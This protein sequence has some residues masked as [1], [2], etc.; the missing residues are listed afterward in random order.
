MH[1]YKCE[2]KWIVSTVYVIIYFA[3]II[4][5]IH[6]PYVTGFAKTVLKGTFCISR[7]TNSKY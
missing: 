3:V 1:E 5:I 7:N 4:I 2:C 6:A